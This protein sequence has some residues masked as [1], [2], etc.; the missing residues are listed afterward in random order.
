MTTNRSI[1][2][3]A[4]REA[5]IIEAN[6]SPEASQFNEAL[7]ILGNVYTS[8]LG[9]E[10]GEPLQPLVFGTG[11]DQ[12][13][14]SVDQDSKASLTG[15]YFPANRR[16]LCN[17]D[18]ETTLYLP[19]NPRDGSRIGVIDKGGDFAT[20]NLILKGNG[21]SIEDADSVTLSTNGV[22]REW[23]YRAELGDWARVADITAD[24]AAPFPREF[25][26]FLSTFLAIRLNPRYGAETS[27]NTTEAFLRM[28]RLV[29]ARYA[30]FEEKPVDDGLVILPSTYSYRY[31]RAS[32][33]R[34][35]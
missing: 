5:G 6:E 35:Y 17:L 8:L 16:L 15:S 24:I 11:G 33:T 27:Q 9:I 4:F 7:T 29:R 34:G 23:F 25:D 31:G 2:F 32:F 21:R 1:I 18:A 10:A 30:Q 19:P 14:A 20:K 22:N 3:Q 12:N 28:R 26:E 13:S